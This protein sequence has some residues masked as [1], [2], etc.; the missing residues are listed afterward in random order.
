LAGAA[1][2]IPLF[3]LASVT[4]SLATDFVEVLVQEVPP[5][6]RYVLE[7]KPVEVVNK[8]D[9][10]LRLRYDAEV[11]QP[12]ELRAGYEPIPDAA[13]VS[14]EPRV[15]DLQ[16]GGK[17]RGK[18]VLYLPADQALAGRRFQV[19]LLLHADPSSGS[20]LSLGLKPRLLFTVAKPGT[21]A[22]T[23]RVVD[24]PRPLAWVKPFA[25]EAPTGRLVFAAEP[26]T[27]ENPWEEPMTYEVV[28]DPGAMAHVALRDGEEPL[29]D[30]EWLEVRPS[31]AVL[32]P[33]A[34]TDFAVEARLPFSRSLFG[35]T[36][37]GAV[38]TVARRAGQPPVDSWNEVRIHVP[39]PDA[40][41]WRSTAP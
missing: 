37:V 23:P 39:E 4:R 31:A 32:A 13:W 5:G 20:V 38:H 11:P 14:F 35:R 19:M 18:T 16:P 22:A 25:V 26:L 40:P 29:P 41:E 27:A 3:G 15:F 28:R 2:L 8:S 10:P 34:R 33:Y 36:F 7:A 17:A 1:G 12:A 6:G 9:L 30:P 21:T 24:T